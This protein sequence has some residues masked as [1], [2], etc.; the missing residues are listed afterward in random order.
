V[1]DTELPTDSTELPVNSTDN[2]SHEAAIA[3]DDLSVVLGATQILSDISFTVAKGSSVALLGANGSGK[4]T[5]VRTILG[6][7]PPSAGTVRVFGV[8]MSSRRAVPW[9]RIG[10]VPQRVSAASGVPATALEVVRS[11]LLAPR[12]LWAKHG[13]KAKE[14]ALAALDAVGLADRARDH[15]QV[16]S[17][18]QSQRVLI[19]RAL[20]RDPELLILDEPLAGIDRTSR[21][22]LAEILTDLHNRGVTLFTVLHQIGEL[23]S[24]VQRAIELDSGR[25]ARDGSFSP[26]EAARHHIDDDCHHGPEST[27]GRPPHHAPV[28]RTET[29]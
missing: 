13:R 12:N 20:V 19:A 9:R 21:E 26:E 15:V 28:L 3:V 27:T 18:G 7:I 10:Y 29:R 14:R 2:V 22:T 17:G 25:I 16:L 6:I 23:A 4:S 11:G 8:P 5:L 24:V 1:N